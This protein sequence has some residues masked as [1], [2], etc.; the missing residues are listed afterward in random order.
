M[1]RKG[2]RSVIPR[3]HSRIKEDGQLLSPILFAMVKKRRGYFCTVFIGA[4]KQMYEWL[5]AVIV[6]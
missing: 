3:A 6:V 4:Q 1:G 2:D 5:D